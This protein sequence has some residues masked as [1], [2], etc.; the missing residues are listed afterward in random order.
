[1]TNAERELMLKI[2]A[3]Q[4]LGQ[5]MFLDNPEFK[6]WVCKTYGITESKLTQL[7]KEVLSS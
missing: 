2:R 3:Q 1:M 6:A 7:Q 4:V 5:G